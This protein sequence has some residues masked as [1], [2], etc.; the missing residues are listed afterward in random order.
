MTYLNINCNYENTATESNVLFQSTNRVSTLLS[1]DITLT[2]NIDLSNTVSINS[3][4]PKTITK[5]LHELGIPSHIKGYTYIR[6]GISMLYED[7]SMIGSIT[8][9]L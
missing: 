1:K 6:E 5:M 2:N 7:P 9:E 4:I 8:K 3:E